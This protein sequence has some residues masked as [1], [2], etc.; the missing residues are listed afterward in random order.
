MPKSE[1]DIKYDRW[2]HNFFVAI[3]ILFA[4][5]V[6]A[7][8]L[9]FQPSIYVTVIFVGTII[10]LYSKLYRWWTSPMRRWNA[11]EIL[12]QALSKDYNGPVII[13]NASAE[14]EDFYKSEL[15]GYKPE[16][17]LSREPAGSPHLTLSRLSE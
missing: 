1:Y 3:H 17:R 2:L 5:S 8:L 4:L 9:V 6:V 15:K 12:A 13:E 7:L 10:C 14:L 11:D 16:V